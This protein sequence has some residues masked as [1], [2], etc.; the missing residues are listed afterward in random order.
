[1]AM[2]AT[3]IMI[4][5]RVKPFFS[6]I[7]MV[8]FLFWLFVATDTV[9]IARRYCSILRAKRQGVEDERR[10]TARFRP[11]LRARRP[12]PRFFGLPISFWGLD[13]T[14]FFAF[15]QK[16]DLQLCKKSGIDLQTALTVSHK[17][18]IF[19]GKSIRNGTCNEETLAKFMRLSPITHLETDLWGKVT[20]RTGHFTGGRARC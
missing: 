10:R 8:V 2:M 16:G 17:P 14:V 4:S 11:N 18:C 7:F 3:T 19:C 13:S 9:P 12:P 20:I 6:F 15:L 1:M 5:T